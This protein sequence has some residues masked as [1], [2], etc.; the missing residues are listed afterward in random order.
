VLIE[1]QKE[2]DYIMELGTLMTALLEVAPPLDPS[3]RDK[4]L[5]TIKELDTIQAT[6][7]IHAI[8]YI[9]HND[10]EAVTTLVDDLRDCRITRE[11]S[12]SKHS[13]KDLQISMNEMREII[14]GYKIESTLNNGLSGTPKRT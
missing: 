3:I 7:M 8:A 5:E 1:L 13:S 10:I 6:A 4:A 2:F 14:L 12:F 9:E 11:T